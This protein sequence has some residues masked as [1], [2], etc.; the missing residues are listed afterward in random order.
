MLALGRELPVEGRGDALALEGV[1]HRLAREQAAPVHPGAEIGRD[2]D[3]GRGGDD[4]LAQ[5]RL[6][7]APISLSSAPKPICVD[8]AGWIVTGK[9][10]R[11]RDLRRAAGGGL[12]CANGTR[13]RNA[14]KRLAGSAQALELVPLM[15]R[16]HVHRRAEGFHLRRRHQA[17]MIVLVAGHRQAE[18]L[19]GVADEADRPVVIDRR[20]RPR[21]ATADRGRRD[22]SSAAPARRRSA[23]R[24]AR[25]PDPG[26]RSRRCRRLRQAAPPWNTSA[27]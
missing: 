17:G 13:S 16:P 3:V 2:G 25:S 12:R 27:E 14:C 10:V 23:S 26:R 18:A 6:A 1:G 8:I 11:H 20:R 7:R 15:A 21:A 22:C 9:L 4:A 5:V 19:D 24:S